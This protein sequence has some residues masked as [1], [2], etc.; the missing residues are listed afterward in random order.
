MSGQCLILIGQLRF[1]GGNRPGSKEFGVIG[2]GERGRFLLKWPQL[3]V[4]GGVF[5]WPALMGGVWGEGGVEAEEN[6][7]AAVWDKSGRER[8]RGTEFVTGLKVWVGTD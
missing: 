5:L 4:D 8:E 6:L 2:R 1:A 7:Q 3:R